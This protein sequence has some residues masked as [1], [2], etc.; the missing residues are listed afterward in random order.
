MSTS[1]EQARVQLYA[2]YGVASHNLEEWSN[3]KQ[4]LKNEIQRVE[5]ELQRLQQE[6]QKQQAPQ[7]ESSAAVAGQVA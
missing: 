4:A 5:A 7:A 2:D 1:L 6:A 3:R